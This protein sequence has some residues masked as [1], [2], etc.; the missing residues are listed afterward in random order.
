MADNGIDLSCQDPCDEG[1]TCGE[2]CELSNKWVF[3]EGF[4]D[5]SSLMI[6]VGPNKIGYFEL[7]HACDMDRIEVYKH[8]NG[9]DCDPCLDRKVIDCDGCPLE[10]TREKPEM[11]L[12]HG[13]YTFRKCKNTGHSLY[14]THTVLDVEDAEKIK[15]ARSMCCC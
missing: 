8:K 10:L 12:P 15:L 11:F 14:V 13:K 3:A 5:T 4:A 9:D 1:P 2:V 7:W 6:S